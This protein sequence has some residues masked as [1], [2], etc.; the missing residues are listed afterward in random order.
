MS[1]PVSQQRA[2]DRI[3]RALRESEPRLASKFAMFTRLAAPDGPIGKERLSP[4]RPLWGCQVALRR[5]RIACRGFHVAAMIS[6]AVVLLIT[7]L[8]L[9]GTAHRG[10]CPRARTA[11]PTAGSPGTGSQGPQGTQ[12]I[13]SPGT[14]VS[15]RITGSRGG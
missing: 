4:R 10:G 1:L 11:I 2:L 9:S 13:G 3:E 5:F 7:G 6:V 15:P 12:A 14:C 8:V